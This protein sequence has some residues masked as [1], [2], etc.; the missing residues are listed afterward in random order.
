MALATFFLQECPTCGRRLQVR[1]NLLGRNVCC[2]H[3]EAEFVSS[4]NSE[5]GNSDRDLMTRVENLLEESDSSDVGDVSR[6][7]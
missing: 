5:P 3:C 1:V 4:L 7:L 6:S 2:P